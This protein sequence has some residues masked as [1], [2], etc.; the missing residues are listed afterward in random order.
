MKT[1]FSFFFLLMAT[2]GA[3]AVDQIDT[4]VTFTNAAGTVNG[5]EI[6]VN[7]DIRT[8]TNN[9]V[10]PASQIMTNATIGGSATNFFSHALAY[11]F[12]GPIIPSMVDSTGADSTNTVKLSGEVGQVMSVTLSAGVGTVVYITNG[13]SSLTALRV[14]ANSLPNSVRT[15]EYTLAVTAINDYSQTAIKQTSTAAEQL[16]GTTNQQSVSGNKTWTGTNIFINVANI[17]FGGTLSNVHLTNIIGLDGIFGGN[18]TNGNLWSVTNNGGR[19]VGATFISGTVSAFTNGGWL[20]PKLTNGVN[21]GNAFSSPGPGEEAQQFGAGADAEGGYSVTVG[22]EAA[23]S[24]NAFQ[25]TVV[26]AYS[27]VSGTNGSAFGAAAHV[28]A[29]NG[30]SLGTETLVA[31]GHT[32]STGVGYNADTTAADQVRLGNLNISVSVAK[33]VSVGNNI[34]VGNDWETGFVAGLAKG[35]QVTNGTAAS[36][37]PTNGAAFWVSSG[38]PQYRTSAANEGAGQVNRIHNRGAEVIGSGSDYSLTTSHAFVDFGGTDAELNTLP[39]AGTYLLTA[40]VQV[41]NGATAAD[42]YYFKFYDATAAADIANSEVKSLTGVANSSTPVRL[43]SIYTTAAA[44]R[45]Q[46]YGRNAAGARGSV[47]SIYT[48]IS[49]VRLY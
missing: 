34:S 14:P 45:I 42:D 27:T 28:E 6:D 22:P 30:T 1:L 23:A 44:A 37:D 35:I 12:D 11:E 38:H 29:L 18:L 43:F 41:D 13:A 10:T 9:V 2:T 46:I 49:Y 25:G 40:T 5:D 3:I 8:F 19:I 47:D 16:L 20:N 4:Y 33:N 48:K 7:G 31:S 15:N 32:N 17:Y 21:H 24:T 36:A 39:T 26:G